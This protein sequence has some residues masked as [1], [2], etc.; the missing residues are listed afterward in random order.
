MDLF[1]SFDH[2]PGIDKDFLTLKDDD[3]V[4]DGPINI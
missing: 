4:L 2:N 1:Y 3:E